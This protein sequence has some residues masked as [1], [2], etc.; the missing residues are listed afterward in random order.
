MSII[1]II[2]FFIGF[3]IFTYGGIKTA[4]HETNSKYS[5]P[6]DKI[7]DIS[8]SL[9]SIGFVGFIASILASLL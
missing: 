1:F 3:G 9:G 6:S 8:A 4:I 2:L 7:F 5:A